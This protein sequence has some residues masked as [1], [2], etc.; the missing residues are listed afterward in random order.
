[1]KSLEKRYTFLIWYFSPRRIYVMYSRS[2]FS[3]TMIGT[4]T[5]PRPVFFH[6]KKF[7]FGYPFW[8]TEEELQSYTQRVWVSKNLGK[9]RKMHW[10]ASSNGSKIFRE[11][12]S[13]NLWINLSDGFVKVHIFQSKYGILLFRW[14]KLDFKGGRSTLFT[15]PCLR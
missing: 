7:E 5:D 12:S 14:I 4:Q 13:S 15:R 11:I 2:R 3:L 9:S 8:N 6:G 1:M 10:K